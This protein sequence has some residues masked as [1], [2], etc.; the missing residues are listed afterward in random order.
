M[1]NYAYI[2]PIT[3]PLLKELLVDDND[4]IKTKLSQAYHILSHLKLDDHTYT[5]LSARSHQ[6]DSFYVYPFG[7]RYEEVTPDNLDEIQ[8][9]KPSDISNHAAQN[10]TGE[11]IH[12]QIYQSRPDINYI[13]HTHSHEIVA[14]SSTKDGLLP[15]NQWALHFYKRVAY[16][17][18]NSLA[19]CSKQSPSIAHDLGDHFTMLMRNHGAL[20]CGRTVQEAMFYTYHLQQACKAQCLTTSMN[21]AIIYPSE[22][23]CQQTVKDLLAFEENLGE[24]DWKA[25]VKLI[26]R[27]QIGPNQS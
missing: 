23:I 16:H 5:H 14:V 27:L 8:L 3:S 13:F 7:M 9:Y 26:H 12:R 2:K 25:W 11:V 18:Y 6:K 20:T 17:D 21:Q 22:A 10:T 19:L 1:L 24:R 4:R 15:I